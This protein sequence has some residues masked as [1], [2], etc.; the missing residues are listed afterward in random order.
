MVVGK[1]V[2]II[3]GSSVISSGNVEIGTEWLRMAHELGIRSIDTAPVYGR[4]EATLGANEALGYNISTKCDAIYSSNPATKDNVIAAGQESAKTLRNQII[5]VYYL[6]GPDDRAP[7]ESSVEGINELYQQGLFK[8]FG[9]SNFLADEIEE[10]I[11]ICRKRKY[12]FPTV[13]QGNYSAVTRRVEAEIFPT[14]RK[15]GIAFYAY[16]PIAAGFLTKVDRNLMT[17]P[18]FD[19]KKPGGIQMN[20]LYNK[21]SYLEALDIWQVI[22]KEEG[23]SQA[24]LAY[25]WVAHHSELKGDQGDGVIIGARTEEQ[26]TGTLNAIQQGP[27]SMNAVRRID[28][29]WDVVKMDASLDNHHC[30]TPNGKRVSNLETTRK[31][32]FD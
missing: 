30:D 31:M 16:S 32:R 19:P 14:L 24:D 1:S 7:V 15:H 20:N 12:V 11:R 13:Y 23:I 3:L 4:A 18:R 28:E 17:S 22:A 6:H 8:R 10:I 25:R 5:D 21:P 26:L 2:E 9:L 29:I 27:L